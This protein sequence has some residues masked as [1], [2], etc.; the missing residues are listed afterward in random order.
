[1]QSHGEKWVNLRHENF[2]KEYAL[3]HFDSLNSSVYTD[4]WLPMKFDQKAK[5]RNVDACEIKHLCDVHEGKTLLML[6]TLQRAF[7]F[8]CGSINQLYPALEEKVPEFSPKSCASKKGKRRSKD[9]AQDKD[10]KSDDEDDGDDDDDD[11]D[12]IVPVDYVDLDI[13]TGSLRLDTVMKTALPIQRKRIEEVHA[14]DKIRVNGER[15][16]KRAMEVGEGDVIDLIYGR[17]RQ[18]SKLL[19][20]KRVK[21]LSVPEYK[22]AKDRVKFKIR[23][24]PNLTIEN[25]SIHPFESMV[26]REEEEEK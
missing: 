18:N 8:P 22:T 15:V 5:K 23:R 25:Y 2:S 4:K 24:W 20:V 26:V 12:E 7:L 13:E 19:E 3:Q 17:S 21:L 14:E 16:Q 9:K 10:D 6:S 11:D 1:M